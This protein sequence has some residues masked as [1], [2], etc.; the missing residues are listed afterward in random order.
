VPREA[1]DVK[2]RRY[3]GE[4]RLDIRHVVGDVVVAQCRGDSAEIYQLGHQRGSWWCT[5]PAKGR[6]CHLQ[7]L[8]WVTLRP[9]AQVDERSERER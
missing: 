5:C 3:L 9:G 2:A 7:A 1:F 8:M 6:C 4:G